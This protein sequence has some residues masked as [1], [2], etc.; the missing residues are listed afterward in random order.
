MKLKFRIKLCVVTC[1]KTQTRARILETKNILRRQNQSTAVIPRL[2]TLLVSFKNDA[3]ANRN[4][5]G[6]RDYYINA[7]K[8]KKSEYNG[9]RL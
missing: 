3:V 9:Q 2:T 7:F 1:Y 6:A 4:T 8:C 5:F